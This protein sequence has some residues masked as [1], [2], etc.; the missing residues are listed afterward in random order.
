MAVDFNASHLH[1]KKTDKTRF[2]ILGLSV[3]F[4]LLTVVSVSANTQLSVPFSTQIPN[5]SWIQP[6]KD[7]CE[8]TSLLM[9]EAF[10]HQ[11]TLSDVKAVQQS[12]EEIVEIEMKLFGFHKD[13]SATLMTQ[14]VNS[15]FPYEARLVAEPSLAMMK[16]ELDAQRPI[17]LPVDGRLLKNPN[18][19]Q[20][21]PSY[22]VIVLIGYD[23]AEQMFIAQDPGTRFGK[24]VRYSFETIMQANLDYPQKDGSREKNM[25]FTSSI[26]ST[27]LLE[28]ADQDQ[29]TKQE[30][31][32]LGTSVRSSDT[33]N[34]GY[35]DGTEVHAGYHPLVN[36]S[37]LKT[38]FLARVQGQQKIYFMEANSRKYVSSPDAFVRRN[39]HYADVYEISPSF[40][41][42]FKEEGS[43]E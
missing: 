20:P 42:Q 34:D 4:V 10:Y 28:D 6:F 32:A 5:G 39:F 38:P 21:A 29:L 2:G 17:I 8:E 14:L 18:Y 11:Q 19:Q 31:L 25:I 22:H 33:D 15:Y 12:I 26:L 37:S 13:T 35:T 41:N 23:D 27:S 7:A 36:E 24:E 9:V 16:Q 40:L 1:K 3:F 43:I 30:E